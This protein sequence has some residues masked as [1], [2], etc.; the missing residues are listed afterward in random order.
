MIN[1]ENFTTVYAAWCGTGKTHFCNSN[2]TAVEIEYWKYKGRNSAKNYLKDVKK[3]MGKASYI[4]I[5]T[6]PAGL[7]ILQNQGINIVLVY[8][9]NELRNEYLDRYIARDDPYDFIGT[10]M[11]YWDVWLN[12]LKEQDYCKHIV[13]KNGE[14][15]SEKL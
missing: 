9:K 4:F 6:D 10:M 11:K 3:Q 1:S 14:Y 8:P 5:S 2:D 12:E 15:L 7:K 13:L